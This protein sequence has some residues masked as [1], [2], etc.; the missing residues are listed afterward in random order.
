MVSTIKSRPNHYETLRLEPSATADEIKRAFER[1]L[2]RPRPF[3]GLAQLGIAYETLKDPTKRQTY[4]ASI[5]IV[6]PPEPRHL[7]TSL[8]GRLQYIGTAP[9]G[10]FKRPIPDLTPPRA[11]QQQAPTPRPDP[12]VEQRAAPVAAASPPSKPVQ[13]ERR[14]EPALAPIEPV[15]DRPEQPNFADAVEGRFASKQVGIAAG[16]LVLAVVLFGAWA[17]WDAGNGTTQEEEQPAKAMT[18]SL[19]PATAQP[20]AT[21]YQP[22]EELR[23]VDAQRESTRRPAAAVAAAEVR[24]ELPRPVE[25]TPAEEQQLAGSDAPAIQEVATEQAVTETQPAAVA[26][27]LPLPN[28]VIAR[29]IQRIGYSCGEVASTTALEGGGPGVFKVT[30]TSGHS[31]QARPVRGRYHFRRIGNR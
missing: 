16:A 28:R 13:L 8:Q 2:H 20:E 3:G 1:E 29:T 24:R 9:I 7:P 25:L 23:A 31:Y 6:P 30:C 10:A 4:D 14:R 18:L 27:S 5:G 22:T 17:G 21:D 12:V 26:A 15:L 19:P 11:P